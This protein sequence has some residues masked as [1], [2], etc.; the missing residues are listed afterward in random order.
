M[1][2]GD[3]STRPFPERAHSLRRPFPGLT[4]FVS[5]PVCRRPQL[6]EA[7]VPRGVPFRGGQQ[8]QLCP[9]SLHLQTAL[10][11]PHKRLTIVGVA[12][13]CHR[14]KIIGSAVGMWW[15]QR[16]VWLCEESSPGPGQP[17]PIKPEKEA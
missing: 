15:H 5:V 11:S 2:Y 4:W 9:C 16:G 17:E 3:V 12:G 1:F 14:F 6:L 8:V 13:G 7:P 10:L